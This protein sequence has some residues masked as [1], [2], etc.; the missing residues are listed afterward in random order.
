MECANC[1]FQNMP[2]SQRC[3]RCSGL[4]N[5][6]DMAI[7]VHPPRATALGK[8]VQFPWRF[9]FIGDRALNSLAATF[10]RF[11]RASVA[12]VNL[13][14]GTALRGIVP[15]WANY[16]TGHPLQALAFFVGYLLLALSGIA[17]LGSD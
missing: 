16:H 17:F 9:R 12:P 2:G 13:N 5:L 15:G 3:A 4:L 8:L 6:A 10:S 11:W 1:K 14:L 7:D